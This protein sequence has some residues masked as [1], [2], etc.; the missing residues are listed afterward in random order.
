MLGS[1]FIWYYIKFKDVGK[2][3]YFKF[4]KAYWKKF[5]EYK[6]KFYANRRDSCIDMGLDQAIFDFL[7]SKQLI[8]E[9]DFFLNEHLPNKFI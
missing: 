8:A 6:A 9:I 5:P 3:S 2:E 7:N 1:Q 4:G